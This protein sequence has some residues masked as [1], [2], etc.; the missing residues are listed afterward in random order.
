[1]CF[2]FGGGEERRELYDLILN[3]LHQLTAEQSPLCSWD[4]ELMRANDVYE[5]EK[6]MR[7]ERHKGEGKG[8]SRQERKRVLKGARKMGGIAREAEETERER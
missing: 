8:E 1:M 6:G 3:L 2:G 4:W 7:G 5:R